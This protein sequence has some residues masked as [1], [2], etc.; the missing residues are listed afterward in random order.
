M[1]QLSIE[2]IMRALMQGYVLG[3]CVSETEALNVMEEEL[4]AHGHNLNE[5]VI[6][7]LFWTLAEDMEIF[8]CVNCAWWCPA[9][10]RAVNQVEEVCSDCAGD[11]EGDF[12]DDDYQDNEDEE[13]A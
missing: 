13:Y 7:D 6:E 4:V 3:S 10:E 8:R 9:H 12:E 5:G 2:S 11:F 1:S